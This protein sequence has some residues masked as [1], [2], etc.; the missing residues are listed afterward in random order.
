MNVIT[1]QILTDEILPTNC[2][3]CPC[4]FAD[5]GWEL[6]PEDT[7]RAILMDTGWN[8]EYTWSYPYK[9]IEE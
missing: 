1:D 9:I 4:Q 2:R 8:F 7:V 5:F 3:Q 6:K